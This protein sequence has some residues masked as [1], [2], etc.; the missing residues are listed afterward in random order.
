MDTLD[1]VFAQDGFRVRLEW[2]PN[3]LRRLAPRCDVV[4]VIDV[5]RFTTAVTVAV[6]AGATVLPYRWHDGTEAEFA[7]EQGAELAS[8]EGPWSLSPVTL[9]AIP[10]GTRLVLPS[11]NGS[12]LAFAAVEAGARTVIAGCLRNAGAVARHIETLDGGGA[13]GVVPA[14]E[15][16]NITTGALRPALEDY[17][18]AGAIVAAIGDPSSS[19]EARAAAAAFT[20]ARAELEATLLAS[21]SGRELVLKDLA[22]DVPM[23]AA[24]DASRAV[25]VL[26]DGAFV[27]AAVW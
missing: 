2:G 6:D 3:G 16:W 12:A 13:I 17:L 22:E 8:A 20:G 15:R 1:D 11:P 19:P 4:V 7:R 14:G 27:D 18:G 10:S 21:A 24:L 26:R 23:A 9:A 25:P 5:L